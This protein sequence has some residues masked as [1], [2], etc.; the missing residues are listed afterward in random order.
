MARRAD[1]RDGAPGARKRA[2]YAEALQWLDR[3][4]AFAPET[5]DL[6]GLRAWCLE[7]LGRSDDAQALENALEAQLSR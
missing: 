2:A 1:P 4:A 7:K 5:R 6:M 3:R